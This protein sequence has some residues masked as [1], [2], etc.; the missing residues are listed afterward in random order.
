[1]ENGVRKHDRTGV[2]TVATFG[3]QM[4]FELNAG[5]PLLTTKRV[6]MRG[7][8]HELLWFLR[9]ETN[10]KYLVEN[11]VKIW[12]EWPFQRYLEANKL[13][14]K[15]PTYSDA[16][17]EEMDRF[18]ER[19]KTDDAFATEWGELGPV[20]GRQWR[21]WQGP[22]GAVYDQIHDLVGRLKGFP[23]S[24]RHIVSAWNPAEVGKMALP[25]CHCLFQFFVAPAKEGGKPRL[26]CQLYQRSFVPRA[27]RT[28]PSISVTRRRFRKGRSAMILRPTRS[29][30]PRKR[31]RMTQVVRETPRLAI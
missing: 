10:I 2:G 4:R 19:I 8:T 3:Y 22:D 28:A 26:S 11:D 1:M 27:R 5:F 14:E 21:A 17:K 7:I 13:T 23:D 31:Q 16:W 29:C 15:F 6:Y 12:N 20:Y 30:I 9:G 18:V 24:R 25:P